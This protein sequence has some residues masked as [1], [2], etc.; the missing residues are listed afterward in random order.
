MVDQGLAVPLLACD[1]F[2]D[3]DHEQLGDN[4]PL[5]TVL[6]EIAHVLSI[7]VRSIDRVV[8][9]ELIIVEQTIWKSGELLRHA[10]LH[11]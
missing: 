2:R 3:V 8:I 6:D 1:S 7:W 4:L 9:H 5:E 10:I 11:F